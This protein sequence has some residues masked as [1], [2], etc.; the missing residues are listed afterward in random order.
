EQL[1]QTKIQN[2]HLASV[3]DHDVAGLDVAMDDAA[4]VGRCQSVGNLNR[5]PQRA[6]QLQWTS[7][8]KLAYVSTFN[9]LHRDEV[10]TFCFVEI[11][12]RA[13]VRMIQRRSQARF[14]LKPLQIRFF[15]S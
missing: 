9:V 1:C 12:D 2:L 15:N 11:K 6:L 5:N 14:A 8:D 10:M 7:V 13:D 3:C 4:R